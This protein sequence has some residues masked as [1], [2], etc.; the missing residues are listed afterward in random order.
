MEGESYADGC[1]AKAQA[2]RLEAE[3]RHELSTGNTSQLPF[4]IAYHNAS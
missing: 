4:T 2:S 3:L 1:Q